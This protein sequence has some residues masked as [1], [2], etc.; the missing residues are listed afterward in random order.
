MNQLRV[1]M[2]KMHEEVTRDLSRPVERYKYS[3]MRIMV[4]LILHVKR[5]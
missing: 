1:V 4:N 2:Y 5:E 3:V